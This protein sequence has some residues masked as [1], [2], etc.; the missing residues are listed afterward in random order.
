LNNIDELKIVSEAIVNAV[1]Y[2]LCMATYDRFVRTGV[3]PSRA[4][5]LAVTL[6]GIGV[7]VGGHAVI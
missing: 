2:V 6:L 5:S 4:A 1:W 3:P 7:A